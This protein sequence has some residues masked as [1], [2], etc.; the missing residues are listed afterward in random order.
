MLDLI[1]NLDLYVLIRHDLVIDH[2]ID[3]VLLDYIKDKREFEYFFDVMMN[4]DVHRILY[5]LY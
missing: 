5:D 4:I 3:M 1:Y 2:D